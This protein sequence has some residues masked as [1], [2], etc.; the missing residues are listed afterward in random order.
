MWFITEVVLK[1]FQCTFTAECDPPAPGMYSVVLNTSNVHLV[2]ETV[3]YI[4]QQ[5]YQ[6]ASGDQT[7]TC[8]ANQ[9][10]SGVALKCTRKQH[11]N[12]HV[13][14]GRIL[15]FLV[16][17]HLKTCPKLGH[18]IGINFVYIQHMIKQC[19]KMKSFL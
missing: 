19:I 9:T 2:G 13:F 4:C 6:P 17:V 18:L 14:D 10:W 7:T 1:S 5:G 11:E 12:V 16:V 3:N 8:M 15:N